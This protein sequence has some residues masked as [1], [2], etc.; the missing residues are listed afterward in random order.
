MKTNF[1]G[2]FGGIF[3]LPFKAKNQM[4]LPDDKNPSVSYSINPVNVSNLCNNVNSFFQI[5]WDAANEKWVNKDGGDDEKEQPLAAP[6]KMSELPGMAQ[7]QQIPQMP[8]MPQMTANDSN[9]IPNIP[10]AEPV[11]QMQAYGNPMAPAMSPQDPN[12]NN[13]PMAVPKAPSL[14]SNMFKMQRK[15]SKP[16][17]IRFHSNFGINLIEFY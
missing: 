1:S 5:I 7:M 2:W 16:K 10:N 12:S 11:N 13:D 8:Q 17:Q 4:I 3:K 9:Q 6:P 14:Q 15:Q